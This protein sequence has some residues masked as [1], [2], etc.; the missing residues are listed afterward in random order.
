MKYLAHLPDETVDYHVKKVASLMEAMLDDMPP[1]LSPEIIRYVGLFHDIGKYTEY[2][3]KHLKEGI[4]FGG[5]EF[6][7]F[8]SSLILYQF[9]TKIGFDKEIKVASTIAV[10]HHHSNLEKIEQEFDT[11]DPS[12]YLNAAFLKDQLSSLQKAYNEIDKTYPSGTL[13]AINLLLEE[14][15]IENIAQECL[16]TVIFNSS[17][18]LYFTTNLILG[19]LVD[20]DIRAV[21]E[22]DSNEQGNR[23]EIPENLVDN[24]LN[25][26][27]KRS[28]IDSLRKEFYDTVTKNVFKCDLQSKF[29]SITAPTGIGKTLTGLSAAFKLRNIIAKETARLPRIIYVLPFTSI[30]D[31][32]FSVIK[33]V[34][35]K[36][37]ISEDILLKHHFREKPIKSEIIGVKDIWNFLEEENLLKVQD[38]LKNYERAYTR[39]ETWDGEIIVTT[40]VRFYET[41]FTNRR[42]EMRRLHRLA[43]SIVIL[44]E[45]QNIPPDYWELTEKA[46]EFLSDEWDTRFILMTATR[47]MLLP[48]AIEL[49]EPKKQFFFTQVSRTELHI[50]K[51]SVSYT[52]IDKWL[53]PK[54]KSAKNFMVV[55]NTIR[56]AQFV[57]EKLKD[58]I[59]DFKIYFLSASLIPIH[60]EKRIKE[61]KD[62]LISN[63]KIA[64]IST[65]VVEA[66]VDLDFDVVIRDLAPLDSIIQ[67]AGRCNRN[68]YSH[69]PAHVFLVRLIDPE[70]H[71][72]ELS[73]YIYDS[74]LI[75][76]TKSFLN[77]YN[78]LQEKDYLKLVEDYFLKLRKEDRKAQN[79]SVLESVETMDYDELSK[80]SLIENRLPLIPV[81]VEFDKKAEDIICK[82]E[83]INNLHPKSYEERI[84]RRNLFKSL[85]PKIWE[86]TVNVPIKA[87]QEIGLKLLPYASSF[88]C[89]PRSHP[90]FNEIY[91]EDTGFTRRF[92]HR[93]IFL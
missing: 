43:G 55:L 61:I 10:R 92:E 33:D 49:T 51:D 36:A 63:Q 24:Y 5:K 62:A 81:F 85:E 68:A 87:A 25:S 79:K 32:N 50:E 39:L 40:F 89:L 66:G 84:A 9:L 4:R 90:A 52:E 80:F 67:A 28:S 27:K 82:L 31:Q 45:V 7:S 58:T 54:I 70:V 11:E 35:N 75:D 57:Y 60:R 23:V 48:Q 29:F 83:Y 47:P 15:S 2:F 37:G 56:S 64:L 22:M 69:R 86:Y 72:K 44:D 73:S 13:E 88:L 17:L 3:Q 21:I 19:M 78:I 42:S 76:E 77:I 91:K 6:H 26:L 93:A 14:N 74:V 18:F 30:I 38:V 46:L 41:L 65:Q 20:A 1:F 8:L 59:D 16:N 34:L 12:W 71:D 53:I